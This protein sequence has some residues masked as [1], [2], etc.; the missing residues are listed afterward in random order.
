MRKGSIHYLV[1]F[2][3]GMYLF[4][5]LAATF[6]YSISNTWANTILPSDFTLSWYQEL[7]SD[8]RFILAMGRTLLI[9][10][11]ALFVS[12]ITM[13]MAVFTITVYFPKWERFIQALVML[14]YAIPGV[15]AAVGLIKMYSSKPIV[16][17]GTV[18]IIVGAYYVLILPYM[19]QGI[20]NSLRTIDVKRLIEAA[21]ILG[22]SKWI[23]F[24]KVIVPNIIPGILV[25]SLLSLSILFGE[26]VLANIL[27][28]GH[29][30][31]IQ[32]Y[33]MKRLKENGHLSSAV[34]ITYFV[35]VLISSLV[36]LKLGSRLQNGKTKEKVS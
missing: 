35:I 1:I 21:E 34:V 17:T 23:A 13:V 3:V 15:V 12:M 7:F 4:L 16:L 10:I 30:E 31:T 11:L 26:F 33:L 27:V 25:S 36:M 19:Y 18:W 24:L 29:F 14:P 20:R 5:P 32:I 9:C 22:A 6:L 2:V 8:Q 28:G